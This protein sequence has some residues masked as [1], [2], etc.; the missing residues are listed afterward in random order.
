MRISFAPTTLSGRV[1]QLFRIWSQRGTSLIPNPCSGETLSGSVRDG[2]R[3]LDGLESAFHPSL[4]LL[5][6][7]RPWCCSDGA[8]SEKPRVLVPR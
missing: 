8:V 4:V 7:L 1:R 6:L 5:D 2:V 3:F